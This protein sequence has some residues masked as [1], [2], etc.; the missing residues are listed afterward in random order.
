MQ[1]VDEFMQDYFVARLL[2]QQRQDA[3]YAPFRQRFHT[4]DCFWDSRFGVLEMMQ[5]EQV[6]S[7]SI[8]GSGAEVIT[9]R[10][11]LTQALDRLRYHLL[12]TGTSWL[13]QS[14]DFE[15]FMCLGK[16]DDKDCPFCHGTGWQ[17]IRH[18][19]GIPPPPLSGDSSGQRI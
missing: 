18:D 17:I 15:C 5:S 12:S 11:A 2:E 16:T 6:L 9:T 8:S 7:T 10:K 19:R 1:T 13:I 14:V 3:S 4:P